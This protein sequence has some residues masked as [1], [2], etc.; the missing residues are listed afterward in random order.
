MDSLDVT[1]VCLIIF[2]GSMIRSTLGFG[3]ALIAMPLL[4]FVLPPRM[5]APLVAVIS[6]FNAVLILSR[7]WRQISFRETGVLTV[8]AL[9]GIPV[10]VWLLNAGNEL[11]IKFLLAIVII[12]FSAWSLSSRKSVRLLPAQ[13]APAFGVVAGILGGAYNTAGPPLVIFG[14]LRQWPAERF[15]ANLQGYFLLGGI[16]VLAVHISRGSVTNDVLR[17][18]AL[19]LPLT[20]VAALLGHQLTKSV[21]T[22]KFIRVVHVCL[23]LIGT[24]LLM[25]V[26]GEL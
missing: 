25:T 18:A 23:L 15:R 10:G 7:E 5:A 20:I 14:T 2:V 3:E 1:L 16:T 19:C 24:L 22:E 11:L 9:M 13:W 12:S 6:S 17:L 21:S 26:A 8:A 4:T